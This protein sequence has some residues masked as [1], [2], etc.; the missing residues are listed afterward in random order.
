[1]EGVERTWSGNIR[2]LFYV[3]RRGIKANAERCCLFA[4]LFSDLHISEE[5]NTPES[6]R[7]LTA[8]HRPKSRSGQGLLKERIHGEFHIMRVKKPLARFIASDTR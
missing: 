7:L 5:C 8:F 1:M 6:H 4:L 2:V 3:Q